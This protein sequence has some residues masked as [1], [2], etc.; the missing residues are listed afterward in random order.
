MNHKNIPVPKTRQDSSEEVL[1]LRTSL[2][3]AFRGREA[4]FRPV[5]RSDDISFSNLEF[6]KNFPSKG[7]QK[8]TFQLQNH[9]CR[10]Y[11]ERLRTWALEAVNLSCNPGTTLGEVPEPSS[12]SVSSSLKRKRESDIVQ[13]DRI[14]TSRGQS[15]TGATT[16]LE[17]KHGINCLI[18]LN[19]TGCLK[20]PGKC[21]MKESLQ[22]FKERAVCTGCQSPF[23]NHTA[24]TGTATPSP[25]AA[26]WCL[27]RQ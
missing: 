23:S 27:V 9:V 12:A 24:V 4:L 21:L 10:R 6:F 13:N 26:G 16:E 15:S 14:R 1:F 22:I 8:N 5:W 17:K 18:T 11:G 19:L 2:S 3:E 20:P 7:E 25:G